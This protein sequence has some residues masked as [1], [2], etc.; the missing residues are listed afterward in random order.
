MFLEVDGRHVK[1]RMIGYQMAMSSSDWKW[2]STDAI[3]I[4]F[5]MRRSR[6]KMYIRRGCLRVCLSLAAFPHYCTDPDVT[7]GNGRGASSCALLG[8]FAISAQVSLQ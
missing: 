3:I 1:T 4:T 2:A 6:G 5:R 7:W 8:R